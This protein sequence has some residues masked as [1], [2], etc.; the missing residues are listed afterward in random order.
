MKRE[1][2]CVFIFIVSMGTG[3]LKTSTIMKAKGVNQNKDAVLKFSSR[4]EAEK[5]FDKYYYENIF[6]LAKSKSNVFYN[7]TQTENYKHHRINKLDINN[8]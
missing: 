5:Y 4:T 7:D 8:D 2:V 6:S 3:C 1:W